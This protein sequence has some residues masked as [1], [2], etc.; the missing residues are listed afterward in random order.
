MGDY[1][2][3]N[4][5]FYLVDGKTV[6]LGPVS[7]KSE[8]GKLPYL[9]PNLTEDDRKASRNARRWLE[10]ARPL[11]PY[12]IDKVPPLDPYEPV[13]N[14]IPLSFLEPLAR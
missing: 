13:L 3:K 7:I 12:G 4:D 6:V 9:Y 11:F 1:L 8:V 14:R 10:L 2:I 5:L